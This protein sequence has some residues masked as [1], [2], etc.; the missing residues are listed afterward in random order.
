MKLPQFALRR[1]SS[2]PPRMTVCESSVLGALP[3]N[4]AKR[5]AGWPVALPIV[6]FVAPGFRA[7]ARFYKRLSLCTRLAAGARAAGSPQVKKTVVF[8]PFGAFYPRGMRAAPGLSDGSNR[9]PDFCQ[10]GD[11]G[12]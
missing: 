5:D 12:T 11:W 7:A 3:G 8:E 1:V 4:D 6:T 2:G 10:I 9:Q